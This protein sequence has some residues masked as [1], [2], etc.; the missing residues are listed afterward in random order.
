MI[1]SNFKKGAVAFLDVLGWK[2][3]WQRRQNVLNEFNNFYDN[4]TTFINYYNDILVP[5]YTSKEL[6][7]KDFEINVSILSDTI[8]I[9]C[10][11]L[12]KTSEHE[13]I[14]CSEELEILSVV[15]SFIMAQGFVL[16]FPFRGALNYGEFSCSSLEFNSSSNPSSNIPSTYLGPAIDEVAY[17]YECHN[18]IGVI[19]I[20][21]NQVYDTI[22]K[23]NPNKL[24]SFHAP[25]VC[26]TTTLKSAYILNWPL[27][28][29][30]P[31]CK[32]ILSVSNNITYDT[33]DD[34]YNLLIHS[35][36]YLS[37]TII[38]PEIYAKISSARNLFE[39]SSSLLEKLLSPTKKE[40]LHET[41]YPCS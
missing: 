4:I 40:D 9:I 26:K 27:M 2:G 24:I 20:P 21:S 33:Y 29:A 3:I 28:Y 12:E 34:L 13:S 5:P 8:I 39:K 23:L 19:I 1:Q 36:D 14:I 32:S 31:H 11:K 38:Q 17:W 15:C 16:G 18:D 22:S 35:L 30:H 10:S 6:K 41:I 37:P 25:F 7:F